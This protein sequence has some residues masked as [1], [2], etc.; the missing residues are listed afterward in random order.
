MQEFPRINFIWSCR[1]ILQ[2]IGE[3]LAAYHI[4]KVEQWDKIFYDGMCR[5][6]T[7]L[8][9]LVIGVIYEERL[10]PLILSTYIIL[11]IETSEKQVDA[12][13]STIVVCGKQFQMWA[14]VLDHSLP[15]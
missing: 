8:Q 9:N 1:T 15:S 11:D 10:R 2:I 14:E 5:R 3:T 6:Q 7:A 12:V 4:S 13:L